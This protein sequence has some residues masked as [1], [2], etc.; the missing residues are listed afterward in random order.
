MKRTTPLRLETD[1]TCFSKG[2]HRAVIL[3]WSPQ[4]PDLLLAR[5]KGQ[6]RRYPLSAAYLYHEAVAK[7]VEAE[8]RAKKAARKKG[9]R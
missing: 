7:H 9:K 1:A 4:S 3:E 8:R 5:L 6:Q 2:K